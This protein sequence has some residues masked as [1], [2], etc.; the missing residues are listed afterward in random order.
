MLVIS[1]LFPALLFSQKLFI[2]NYTTAEGLAQNQVFAIKQDHLGFMWFGTGGG[3]SRYDGRSF[4]NFTKENGLASNVI[5]TI[6][7]SSDNRLWLGTDEGLSLYISKSDSF[8][9]YNAAA[10]VNT[11]GLGKGTVRSILEDNDGNLWFGT[12]GGLS[13]LVKKTGTFH[14]FTQ[15]DG[16]PSNVILCLTKDPENTLYAGTPDGIGIVKLLGDVKVEISTVS[17]RNGLINNRIEAVF[18]DSFKRLWIGTPVG[19]TKIENNRFTNFTLSSGLAHNSVR[20]I[21]QNR[22]GHVWFM[23]E[24]GISYTDS[25]TEPVVFK[26]YSTKNG[27]GGNFFYTMVEDREL[28][29]WFGTFGK[30]VS[31]LVSEDLVSFTEADGLINDAVLSAAQDL[32]GRIFIGTTIGLSIFDQDKFQSYAQPEGLNATEIWDVTIDPQGFV[33][34]GT[35]NG[36][37]LL[38]PENYFSRYPNITPGES[39]KARNLIAQSQRIRDFYSVNLYQFP[40]LNGHRIVDIIVDN[41]QR[42]WFAATDGG[43][44]YITIDNQGQFRI[45]TFTTQNGLANN[46]PWCL[47]EDSQRRIWAGMIGGGLAL[48][49]EKNELFYKYTQK[50]GLADDVALA[51]CE[52]GKGNLWIGSE[53]GLTRLAIQHLP[54]PSEGVINL[55]EIAKTFSAKDGLTDNSV[56]AITLDDQGMLWVGTNNGLN[57]IDPYSE[58]IVKTFTKKQGLI[59]NEISTD[60]SLIT[61]NNFVWAG[62]AGGLTR[63]PVKP[64]ALMAIPVPTVYLVNFTVQDKTQQLT[65]RLNLNYFETHVTPEDTSFFESLFHTGDQAILYEENNITL[66]F[67][68][69]SFKD[70]SDVRYRYRLIGFEKEWSEPIP[71]NRVRYTNLNEGSYI[72]EIVACNGLDVWSDKPVSVHFRILTPFWKSWWFMLFVAAFIGLTVY[73]M[74][75]FR[76]SLVRQRTAEL[77]AKVAKRT[78][79]LMVQKET[80]ERVLNELRETQMHLVHSEKMASLGQMVAGIAHEINNPI[81][82]VKA[83]IS[84]LEKKGH[85]VQAMFYA[86]SDVFDFFETFKNIKDETHGAFVAKLTEI[87][88]LIESSKFEKFLSDFPKIIHEMRDGVERTQKIVEDLR[89]FSRLDESHF[90]EISLV[91]SIESTLNILKNEYKSRITIH[92][93]FN[94]LPLIYCNPGHINQVL[95][96]LLM[97][98]FQSIEGEG[99]VWIRT[100]AG[101][102][103]ILISIKDNGKGIPYEIQHKV[104]DPFFT[105]KPIGKGTGLG[106]AISYKILEAHKGTIFFESTPGAGTE[107]KITLPIRKLA[108]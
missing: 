105:T 65:R 69:P 70:E 96:N 18:Y 86:F 92:R 40:E 91:D 14:N 38:I 50:E 97:N 29:Y 45:R 32:D 90:K 72:F 4:R 34:L 84:L 15:K 41:R 56:N 61:D 64:S 12:A 104:Y 43:I 6:F 33:W 7:E 24:S 101:Q 8:Y 60:N 44:G 59:D 63:L 75:Q 57:L 73:T 28:N 47:Y 9:N 80:V 1:L 53:R 103:N 30:G 89:N 100:N 13:V 26:N 81:T 94:Q 10:D 51:L 83:N 66:D 85:Q 27:F 68:S 16:L 22:K 74:Y 49:D 36:M 39:E 77:E 98:A 54:P 107:F 82:Y 88:K 2:K 42:I 52:D 76:I 108:S 19:M 23:T 93:N 35:F 71:E 37:K 46:N 67:V 17:A 99:D 3:L 58:K 78:R 11:D 106:L 102:N 95:M 55:H 62:T 87:D 48:Y 31:K 5:R 25:R 21:A 79:E 20:G